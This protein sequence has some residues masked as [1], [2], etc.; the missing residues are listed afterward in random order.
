M[1]LPIE[2]RAEMLCAA[3]DPGPSTFG[4]ALLYILSSPFYDMEPK[5]QPRLKYVDK[6]SPL[7]GGGTT[8]WKGLWFLN[9]PLSTWTIK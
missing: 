8:I 6:F 7:I 4:H 1:F 5:L 3:F 9:D 2:V